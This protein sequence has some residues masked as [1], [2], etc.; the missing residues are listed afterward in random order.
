[1]SKAIFYQIYNSNSKSNPK[2]PTLLS[3]RKKTKIGIIENLIL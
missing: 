3:K 2:K 1:M